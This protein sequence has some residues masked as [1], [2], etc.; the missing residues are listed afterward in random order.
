MSYKLFNL[1]MSYKLFYDN[2]LCGADF[3]VGLENLKMHS[4][5]TVRKNRLAGCSFTE[6]KEIKAKGRAIW[7]EMEAKHNGVVVKA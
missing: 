1:N 3:Q 6:D 7:G 2:W 5:G 4:V